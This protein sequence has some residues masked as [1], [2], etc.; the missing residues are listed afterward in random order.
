MHRAQSDMKVRKTKMFS[1]RILLFPFFVFQIILTED[2]WKGIKEL[3]TFLKVYQPMAT[4]GWGEVCRLDRSWLCW[5]S[6]WKCS[7]VLRSY[8]GCSSLEFSAWSLSLKHLENNINQVN[9]RNWLF[10]LQTNTGFKVSLSIITSEC[11]ACN[12]ARCLDLLS[13]SVMY[14]IYRHF[15]QEGSVSAALSAL[16]YFILGYTLLF[17]QL[18]IWC[19][20]R[21]TQTWKCWNI[22]DALSIVMLWSLPV[23]H[24]C[25][26]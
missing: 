21:S 12:S 6:C 22:W 10:L 7:G 9:R 2:S 25:H 24:P 1:N 5:N 14:M 8:W 23:K 18:Y 15:R 20:Y 11:S 4:Q 17:I 19:A 26:Q 13:S 3:C 16:S